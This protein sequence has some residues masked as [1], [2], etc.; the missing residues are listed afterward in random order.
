[1]SMGSIRTGVVAGA[2]ALLVGG[3]AIGPTGGETVATT[4]GQQPGLLPGITT[5]IFGAITPAPA[6]PSGP[7]GPVAVRC[8]RVEVREGTEVLRTYDGGGQGDPNRLRWQAT[9]VS[10]ERECRSFADSVEYR[11]GISGRVV[12]GP[13]G[14]PGTFAVPVRVALVRGGTQVIQSKLVRASVTITDGP[15]LFSLVEEFSLP[16]APTDTLDGVQIL[17]GFDP[18]PERP[19]RPQRRQRVAG[20]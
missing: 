19:Q 4:G 3:C 20:Q 17:V 16:R 6:A 14:G 18:T 5:G 1:M 2:L 10:A 13:R 15:A 8:N 9:V 12:V 7:T 11:V